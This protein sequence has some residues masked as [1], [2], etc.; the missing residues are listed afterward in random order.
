MT[1]RKKPTGLPPVNVTPTKWRM[2][3]HYHDELHKSFNWIANNAPDF[4]GTAADHT[5]ISRNYKIARKHGCY[6]KAPRPGCRNLISELEAAQGIAD[7]DEGRA[8]DG[9]DLQRQRFPEIPQR[10]VCRMLFK[11]GLKGFIRRH[12]VIL[13]PHNFRE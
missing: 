12:K 8:T 10:T 1:A 4:R 13:T 2:I 9:A 3:L 5:T 11:H 7:I 6:Y